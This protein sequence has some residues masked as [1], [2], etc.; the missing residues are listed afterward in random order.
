MAFVPDHP[1]YM[2]II[3][4]VGKFY[5]LKGINYQ[6]EISRDNRS[7]MAGRTENGR[8]QA[9][10]LQTSSANHDCRRRATGGLRSIVVGH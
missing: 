4:T 10:I 9:L 7:K 5:V 3:K 1:G 6:S 2:E 8:L